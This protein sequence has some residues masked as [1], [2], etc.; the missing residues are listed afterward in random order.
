MTSKLRMLFLTALL[1]LGLGVVAA[2]QPAEAQF[3]FGFGFGNP[4]YGG[5]YPGYG[6]G[7]RYG[8]G[9]GSPYYGHRDHYWGPP[10][11]YYGRRCHW[12]RRVWSPRRGRYVVLRN[13]RRVCR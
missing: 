8:H 7:P 10:R 6:Y 9:Y 11:P 4:Y 1:A 12:T 5:G 2:P 13:P 3:G